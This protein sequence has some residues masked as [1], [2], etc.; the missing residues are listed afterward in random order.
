MTL[1]DCQ[2]AAVQET[3][4]YDGERVNEVTETKHDYSLC[5]NSLLNLQKGDKFVIYV[6]IRVI[7]FHI[8]CLSSRIN[9]ASGSGNT[10]TQTCDLKP[11]HPYD[12]VGN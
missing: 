10:E 12:N 6:A 8:T 7:R 2:H 3:V 1:F 9:L 11:Y 4:V 5:Y